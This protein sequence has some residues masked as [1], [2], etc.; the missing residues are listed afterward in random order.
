M[1]PKYTQVYSRYSKYYMDSQ[2][3]CGGRMDPKYTRVLQVYSGV[4]FQLCQG[5]MRGE[6]SASSMY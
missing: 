6:R 2:E 5:G 1:D 3:A 4:P